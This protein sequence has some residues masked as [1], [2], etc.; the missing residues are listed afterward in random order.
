[1]IPYSDGR[2]FLI[3]PSKLTA[4]LGSVPSRRRGG[5]RGG[6]GGHPGL[7]RGCAS[8]TNEN[9]KPIEQDKVPS[10]QV[11]GTRALMDV[12]SIRERMPH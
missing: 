6:E 12:A 5:P 10:Q 9:R 4:A 1:M 8:T 3:G 7:E 2:G 11:V